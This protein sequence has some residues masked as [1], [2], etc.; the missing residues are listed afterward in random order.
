METGAPEAWGTRGVRPQVAVL[1][2]AH[3]GPDSPEDIPAY[4]R[5]VRGG[6]EAPP[7]LIEEIGNRYRQIG[8]RSPLNMIT[9]S[10]ASRL[11]DALGIPVYVGMRHW[12]PSISEAVGQMA[13]VGIRRCIT[14]C[15]APHAGEMTSGAY[16]AR[17]DAA[18]REIPASLRPAVTFVESWHTQPGYLAG[19]A[20]NVRETLLRFPPARR[21][22]VLVIFT[23][24][25]LPAS[26]LQD[27][28][29]Y[30]FQIHET[31]SLVAGRL[32]Q[33]ESRWMVSYQS[34]RPDGTSW[35]GP[36]IESLLPELARSGETDVLVAPV[37]FV[38]DNLEVLYDID[39]GLQRI[40][41]S[42]A[43]RLE[44]TPMLN[45]SPPLVHALADVVRRHLNV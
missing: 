6:R 16:R 45:D 34:A 32:G 44:R 29:P 25:S 27:G 3:G 37:G 10:V 35:L 22:G 21:G 40:A 24:H 41:H 2:L 42:A 4:L 23:A 14:V 9:R 30:S 38:A 20:A 36:Q 33:P 7:Q 15:M 12:S 18:V 5:D 28:D 13:A 26:V 19:I 11:H 39:V 1:L 17:L 43:V 31:A 8:G